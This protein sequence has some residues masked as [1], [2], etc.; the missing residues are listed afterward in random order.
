MRLKHLPVL[1]RLQN[2]QMVGTAVLLENLETDRSAVLQTVGRQLL[3]LLGRLRNIVRSHI[4]VR[5][6]VNRLPAILGSRRLRAGKR[7][8]DEGKHGKVSVH[9]RSIFYLPALKRFSA[10]CQLTTFHHAAA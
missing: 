9:A 5:D 6:D 4:D 1:P 7:E 8:S 10:S 2:H 3:Q